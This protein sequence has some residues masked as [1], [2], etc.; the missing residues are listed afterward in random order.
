MSIS[1]YLT[2]QYP[3]T[4]VAYSNFN[5]TRGS[6]ASAYYNVT[7]P[8]GMP[9]GDYNNVEVYCTD[10]VLN[11][12]ESYQFTV[13]G[14]GSQPTTTEGMIYVVVI[15]ICTLLLFLSLWGVFGIKG[16]NVVDENGSVL[17]VNNLKYLKIFLVA[18]AYT[19]LV[20]LA[21]FGMNLSYNFSSFNLATSIFNWIFTILMSGILPFL[22]LLFVF[23]VIKFAKDLKIQ[24]ILDVGGEYRGK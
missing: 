6:T 8:A 21:Y 19:L 4:T 9:I 5:L 11:G 14:N 22:S 20:I 18:M 10:G 7:L 24:K 1:C 23:M 2:M 12:T 15:F 13:R 3:N 16:G 17:H